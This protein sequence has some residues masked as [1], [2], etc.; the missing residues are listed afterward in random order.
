MFG[1]RLLIGLACTA[2]V[3][4]GA[5]AIYGPTIARNVAPQFFIAR[6]VANTSVEFLPL[7]SAIQ[8]I[9]PKIQND[10]LR[11]ET[12]LSI[13]SIDGRLAE[14]IPPI[15]MPA[16][17]MM[18]LRNV[19]RVDAPR[20]TFAT[21]LSLQMIVTTVLTA[22]LHLD[23]E[24][25]AVGI[26][27]L[28]NYQIGVDP[29]RLGSMLDESVLGSMIVPPGV[30]DDDLF[31][32]MYSG[33]FAPR[34]YVD[35]EAFLRAL[36]NFAL[37]MEFEFVS[38]SD[39]I[40]LYQIF[41]PA[42]QANDTI[43]FLAEG[44]YFHHD[45]LFNLTIENNRLSGVRLI[46]PV[47]SIWQI[48]FLGG[49]S[50]EFDISEPYVGGFVRANG[51]FI[52][53]NNE[54]DFVLSTSQGDNLFTLEADGSINLNPTPDLGS[55]RIEAHLQNMTIHTPD[56]DISLN[57]RNTLFADA[58]PIVFDDTNTRMLTDL[59]IFDLLEMYSRVEDTPIGGLLS[60]W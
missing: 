22:N 45:M 24:R 44:L 16:L 57:I 8:E 10:P 39:G 27:E 18:S 3:C 28:F 2:A 60:G 17:G 32:D 20:Q 48:G 9:A 34:D 23:S 50:V 13:N 40:E 54:V 55:W 25:I 19:I 41:V 29:R 31:Y 37:S 11:N 59:H 30:I 26:P 14:N 53:N 7:L 33:V 38:R 6:A 43:N 5:A 21:E 51:H 12:N 1:K 47:E 42:A 4:T 36:G 58:N 52:V 35:V 46:E 49:G 15:A 56:I